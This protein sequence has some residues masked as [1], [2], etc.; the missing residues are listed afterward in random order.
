[1][2]IDPRFYMHQGDRVG[3]KALQAIP[4]FSAL[5][6]AYMKIYN[7]RQMR[8][9]NMSSNLRIN[10]RQLSKYYR[11]LPPICK[12]LG[13]EVPEMYLSLNAEVNAH[14]FGD[15]KPYIVLNSGLLEVIP[16]E[17]IPTVIAHECGHI[18]CHHVLYI[19][20]GNFL[21]GKFL[22]GTDSILGGEEST[23]KTLI[24]LP[25]Q[26]AYYHWRRCGEFSAD[27]AAAICDGSAEGVVSMCMHFAGYDKRYAEQ[28][29]PQVFLDQAVEYKQMINDSSWDRTL[30]MIFLTQTDHPFN[31]IRAY[32]CNEWVKNHR[33]PK[34]VDYSNI[35]RSV[36]PGALSKYM[37]E[38]PMLESSKHCIGKN[39]EE[40]RNQLYQLGFTS[41][42]LRRNTHK[43]GFVSEGEVTRITV[44]GKDGFEAGDWL[45]V[46]A[47]VIIEFYAAET[48]A[49]VQAA[50]KG[51]LR[52]PNSSKYYYNRPYQETAAEFQAAGFFN[53]RFEEQPHGQ[54]GL[55]DRNESVAEISINGQ[56]QFDSGEWFDQNAKIRITYRTYTS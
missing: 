44:N 1:M 45:P 35:P 39:Y 33:F 55:F 31:A 30:E 20:M 37:Q 54:K 49:E 43:S 4:G 16:E 36:S 6:K 12:K 18:A 56:T 32:E 21:F 46:T 25:I 40:V 50:H 48:E 9:L 13:I 2:K 24:T 7:E 14:T 8:V 51:Q 41:V 53:I 5:Y 19:N 28:A 34:I 3:L 22:S 11:M 10:E 52:T 47:D 23:I 29:D 42:T 27:R 17:L 38:V 15:T 26:M